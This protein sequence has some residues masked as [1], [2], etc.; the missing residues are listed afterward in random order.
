MVRV[1]TGENRCHQIRCHSNRGS[2]I[3]ELGTISSMLVVIAVFC[4]NI[5][6]LA[7]GSSINDR[8]CRDAARS[9]AQASNYATALQM[10]EAA[11]VAHQ[12]DGYFIT[13]PQITAS[14]FVYQDYGGNPPSNT[15]PYVQVTTTNQVRVP[16]P[17]FYMGGAV[18]GPNGTITCT[19]TYNFP[20]VK[21]TLYLP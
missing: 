4:A 14:G 19:R 17:L 5:G 8:A 9:A 20:I 13:S 11:L 10:A 3:I 16:A 12:A 1:L 15:S 7:L 21:T 18:F 2:S 6:I